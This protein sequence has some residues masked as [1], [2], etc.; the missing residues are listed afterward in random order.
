MV[1]NYTLSST[2]DGEVLSRPPRKRRGKARTAT[3]GTNLLAEY[4]DRIHR[5]LH[6]TSRSSELE[7][8]V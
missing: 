2:R 5:L 3:T 6:L 8:S 1:L 4:N 7:H